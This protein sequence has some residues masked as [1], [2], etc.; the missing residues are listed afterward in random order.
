MLTSQDGHSRV[1]IHLSGGD[2][3][4]SGYMDVEIGQQPMIDPLA[5]ISLKGALKIS[6]INLFLLL[7]L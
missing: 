4:T 7:R 5:G 1:G 2:R 6:S 3:E